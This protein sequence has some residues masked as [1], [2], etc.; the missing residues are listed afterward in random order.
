M[1]RPARRLEP[2]YRVGFL[3]RLL[4]MS[5]TQIRQRI[6]RGEF[7]AYQVSGERGDLS[8]THSGLEAWFGEHGSRGRLVFEPHLRGSWLA[9]F[10][11]LRGVDFRKRV[12][13]G[14]FGADFL[15]LP[16]SGEV[17]VPLAGVQ[18]YLSTIEVVPA[19]RRRVS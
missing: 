7:G 14:D 13:R 1:S 4:D 6:E 11:G 10:A 5:P 3:A 19:S 2:R 15:R 9:E 12:E 16:G 8:V 18:H 17:R